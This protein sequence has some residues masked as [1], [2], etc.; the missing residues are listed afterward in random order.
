[1]TVCMDLFILS[2]VTILTGCLFNGAYGTCTLSY[3]DVLAKHFASST[4]PSEAANLQATAA[5]CT[6]ITNP[7]EC[8]SYGMVQVDPGV[9]YARL[10]FNLTAMNVLV[11]TS[12]CLPR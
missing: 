3:A 2:Y 11:N 1:M 4:T 9:M 5:V 10:T 12:E 8:H 6:S 7:D